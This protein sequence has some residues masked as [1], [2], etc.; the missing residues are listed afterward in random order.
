[1]CLFDPLVM[2]PFLLRCLNAYADPNYLSK[3]PR[4][5]EEEIEASLESNNDSL[6]S[7]LLTPREILSQFPP[8]FLFTSDTDPCLDETVS[9]S[10]KLIQSGMKDVTLDIREGLPHGFL[11]YIAM[12]VE[13]RNA[14]N[15]ITN[16]LKGLLRLKTEP[17]VN[18]KLK[19]N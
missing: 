6:L 4:S 9:F 2:F 5:F 10:N 13:C 18:F 14:L 7:P 1:M 11:S 19:I 8:T 12:S 16:Q 15:E 3:C 17:F